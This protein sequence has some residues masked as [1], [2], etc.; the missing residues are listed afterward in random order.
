[1]GWL[2]KHEK[3]MLNSLIKHAL[4]NGLA[5]DLEKIQAYNYSHVAGELQT[6]ILDFLSFLE[7]ALAKN[8]DAQGH[9]HDAQGGQDENI[10]STIKKLDQENVDLKQVKLSIQRAKSL[11]NKAATEEK[12]S[13]Q[14]TEEQAK[15]LLFEH[16]LKNWKPSKGDLVN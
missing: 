15:T 2:L 9:S 1:M 8:I 7:K 10:F 5:V 6:T 12:N 3:N 14:E 13:P 4:K 11:L 16:I